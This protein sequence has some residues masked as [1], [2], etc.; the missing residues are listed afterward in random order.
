MDRAD[1]DVAKG[2][3]GA[4]STGGP[5]SEPSRDPDQLL[6]PGEVAELFGVSPKTVARWSDAGR[7]EALRTLGGHRRYRSSEIH[8]LLQQR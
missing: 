1:P 3:D 7:F 4:R 6:T 5:A 2:Q 8:A